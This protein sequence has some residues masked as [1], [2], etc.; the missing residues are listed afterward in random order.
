MSLFRELR[1]RRVFRLAGLYLIGA[2]L[3]LQIADV[4][5]EPIGL[6]GWAMSILVWTIIVGFLVAIALS[7]RYDLGKNGLVRV[8][9]SDTESSGEARLSGMD[10]LILAGSLVVAG[11]FTWALVDS[12]GTNVSDSKVPVA[13]TI[14]NSVAVLP[15]TNF[16]KNDELTYYGDGIA[17]EVT[18]HLSLIDELAVLAFAVSSRYNGSGIDPRE[19]ARDLRVRYLVS[20]SLRQVGES[21]RVSATLVEAET[22][23]Q[24]WSMGEDTDV[25]DAFSTQQKITQGIAEAMLAE[26]N[27]D[28]D[29]PSLVGGRAPDPEA[30]DLYLRGRSIWSRR[31]AEDMRSAVDKLSEAVRVDPQFAQGWSALASAY[32]VW[33]AYSLEGRRTWYLAR[34]AAQKALELD[35]TLA[36]PRAVLAD[37]EHQERNWINA[38]RLYLEALQIEPENATINYWYSEHLAKTGRYAE[39]TAWLAKVR[40][41]DPTYP[42]TLVDSIFVLA[43]YG[44]TDEAQRLFEQV[45]ASGVRLPV[46]NMAGFIVSTLAGDFDRARSVVEVASMPDEQKQ[47][48]WDFIDVEEGLL[49]AE[50]LVSRL[51]SNPESWPYYVTFVWLTSRLGATD[52]AIEA[53]QQQIA[54]GGS[55]ETR[56]L[57]GPQHKLVESGDFTQLIDDIGLVEYWKNVAWGDF[58][59]IEGGRL[60]CESPGPDDVPESVD[61]LMSTLA[62]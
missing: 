24:L 3:V 59:D 5:F 58:C 49:D 32:L 46:L 41:L 55:I 15:F 56:M 34:D 33:P 23:I 20:G 18:N 7:W 35:S 26:L 62:L 16:T 36:E 31:G 6:P 10:Y 8:T 17:E 47:I 40:N 45:W 27:L 11:L 13:E 29:R 57:W 43:M 60:R 2:W 48:L 52:L 14:E 22:G 54:T 44:R 50:S 61:T 19:I 53:L 51:R 38:N 25:L 39:S 42:P 28:L 1:R 9:R 4:T 30:Y 37:I 12:F 21:L